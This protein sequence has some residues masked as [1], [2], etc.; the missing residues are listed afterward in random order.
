MDK[1]KRE[2]IFW[3]E[4]EKKTKKTAN[5][6]R[7]G[8]AQN[9]AWVPSCLD[10]GQPP[11][12]K[13]VYQE[14][15]TNTWCHLFTPMSI[16]GWSPSCERNLVITVSRNHHRPSRQ[17][18]CDGVLA[19]KQRIEHTT[20]F[21]DDTSRVPY[22]TAWPP[23][24]RFL[25]IPRPTLP[26]PKT[27]IFIFSIVVPTIAIDNMYASILFFHWI[28]NIESAHASGWRECAWSWYASMFVMMHI[29][30]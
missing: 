9:R 27:A 26:V 15:I 23:F 3:L 28:S 4:F 5:A 22:F 19:W 20:I 16:R 25:P 14:V 30:R 12:K 17:Q 18:T 11:K 21:S 13:K 6:L 2:K 29:S 10:F 24:V 1:F 7:N 8:S